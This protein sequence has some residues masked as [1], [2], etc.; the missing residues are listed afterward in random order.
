[1]SLSSKNLE[2]S[3][4]QLFSCDRLLHD[5]RDEGFKSLKFPELIERLYLNNNNQRIIRLLNL[6]FF[7]SVALYFSFYFVDYQLSPNNYQLIWFV[8]TAF[9]LPLITLAFY[10]QK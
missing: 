9:F 8:R 5:V 7:W 10:F 2:V 3:E 4:N 6:I 1:M